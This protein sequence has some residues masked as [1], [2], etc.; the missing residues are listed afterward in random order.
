MVV[1][2]AANFMDLMDTT[3]VNVALPSIQQD[4]AATSG[5]LEWMI[6]AYT[7]GLAALLV[8]GGRLGDIVGI[9]RIFVIGISGF[10]LASLVAAMA[11]SAEWLVLARAMQGAC[12]GIMVPQV[13]AGVQV[14]YPPQERAPIY[15]LVGFITGSAA[16]AG[17]VLSGCLISSGSFGLGWRAIFL[18]NVPAGIVLGLIAAKAVPN[19][20]SARPPRLDLPGV[21]LLTAAIV[22]LALP[23]IDGR[24]EGWPWWSWTLLGIAPVLIAAFVVWQIACERSGRTPLI[25]VHLLRNRDYAAGNVVNFAFQAGLVGMFLV[26]TV[27]VQQALGY[28]AFHSGLVWLGFSLGTLGGSVAAAMLAGRIGPPLMTA[29]ATLTGGTVIAVV[30]ICRSP[31]TAQPDWWHL[32][33]ALTIG[34]VGLGLVTVPLFDAALATVPTTDAGTASGALS[35]VQQVGG[36]LGVAVIGGIFYSSASAQPSGASMTTALHVASW[37]SVAA[38]GAAAV[39]ALTFGRRNESANTRIQEQKVTIER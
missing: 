2:I 39:A 27:Y 28:S 9:Q 32:S 8:T 31:G 22:C 10:T 33:G 24:E 18:V 37:G 29:G 36:T 23:L 6:G 16:V 14:M 38:F 3:V 1:L 13:L 21:G 19:S 26:L 7:L 5:Q 34:G 4:L 11:G 25:P 20:R 30:A 12:A 15:G 17:P 35:T